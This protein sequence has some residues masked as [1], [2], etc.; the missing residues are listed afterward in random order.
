MVTARPRSKNHA[1]SVVNLTTVD[2][3]RNGLG[4]KAVCQ[5]SHSSGI[6]A[7][8]SKHNLLYARCEDRRCVCNRLNSAT[9]A[10]RHETFARKLGDKSHVRPAPFN[11]GVDVE[12]A[13]F[14]DF[15]LVEDANDVEGIANI[16]FL[17]NRRVLT[18]RLRLS[19][20]STGIIRGLIN[21][22]FQR[23]YAAISFRTGGFFPGE[24]VRRKY[25]R[26]QP[27]KQLVRQIDRLQRRPIDDRICN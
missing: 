24:T 16:Y 1:P 19:S 4:S 23:S 13:N 9:V 18:S 26:A 3:R 6:I 17:V 11:A 2:A 5:R 12:D 8:A 21:G 14:V 7:C 27:Q 10:Q 20:N 15:L 22:F 25:F